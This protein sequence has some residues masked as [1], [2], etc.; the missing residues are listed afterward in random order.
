MPQAIKVIDDHA[1]L[2][3]R[4]AVDA[5]AQYEL[6]SV[7]N[8]TYLYQ[9][10]SVAGATS[11]IQ[12]FTNG[13]QTAVLKLPVLESATAFQ[14]LGADSTPYLTVDTTPTNY[15]RLTFWDYMRFDRT[16]ITF[17]TEGGQFDNYGL[18]WHHPDFG[19]TVIAQFSIQFDLGDP[20]DVKLD[21]TKMLAIHSGQYISI[22]SDGSLYLRGATGVIVD[23]GTAQQNPVNLSNLADPQADRD[24]V[25]RQYADTTYAYD[26]D[27]A[28]Y[29]NVDGSVV[30]ATSQAQ[31]FTN[32]IKA[33]SLQSLTD[34]VDGLVFKNAAG[35]SIMRFN[36]SVQN[37]GIGSSASS[38]KRLS[39]VYSVVSDSGTYNSLYS[40]LLLDGTDGAGQAVG[41]GAQGS[42]DSVSDILYG[43]GVYG[44]GNISS[45]TIQTSMYGV[46]GQALLNSA[47]NNTNIL[48]G[49]FSNIQIGFGATA[50][51]TYGLLVEMPGTALG[52]IT[53]NAGVRVKTQLN[54]NI[55]TT[56]AILTDGGAVEFHS[57]ASTVTPLTVVTDN[58]STVPALT[59]KKENDTIL[60]E[61]DE[62]GLGT[63]DSLDT[64]TLF[65]QERAEMGGAQSGTTTDRVLFV[66][67]ETGTL[68]K[69]A[70]TFYLEVNGVTSESTAVS[71]QIALA[72]GSGLTN[73]SIYG[74]KVQAYNFD[75]GSTVENL[76]GSQI[77]CLNVGGATQRIVGLEVAQVA[78]SFSGTASVY[79]V[80]GNQGT[81]YFQTN[82]DMPA[83]QLVVNNSGRTTE[84]MSLRQADTT[85]ILVIDENGNV[86][87]H[88]EPED[89]TS[90][91][92]HDIT[93][94]INLGYTIGARIVNT[95]SSTD[96][97]NPNAYGNYAFLSE[98]YLS[99]VNEY[100]GFSYAVAG[101]SK[102]SAPGGAT[103][104]GVY[105]IGSAAGP[106]AN[107]VAVLAK[108][109]KEGFGSDV[110]YVKG[111]VVD[112][113]S[114][115]SG[116]ATDVIGLH[117]KSQNNSVASGDTFNLLSES[118]TAKFTGG[119][120]GYITILVTPS[121]TNPAIR[122]LASDDSTVVLDIDEAALRPTR[123][124]PLSTS[125]FISVKAHA[126]GVLYWLQFEDE[127]DYTFAYYTN[128]RRYVHQTY[129]LATTPMRN[130][131]AT[132]TETSGIIKALQV[133]NTANPASA[134]TASYKGIYATSYSE[135]GS[136][137]IN[138]LNAIEGHA[139]HQTANTCTT[140][141]S[142]FANTQ[143]LGPVTNAYG[144]DISVSSIGSGSP[145]TNGF[146]VRSIPGA[147]AGGTFTNWYGLYASGANSASITTGY[148]FYATNG[149]SYFGDSVGTS[150]PM[151][152]QAGASQT[153]PIMQV[154]G[155]GDEPYFKVNQYGV[156]VA[157]TDV[158]LLTAMKRDSLFAAADTSATKV[159]GQVTILD[160]TAADGASL[161]G[162]GTWL[163]S[164]QSNITSA[165]I[166]GNYVNATLSGANSDFNDVYLYYAGMT[167]LPATNTAVKVVGFGNY[168]PDGV[169]ITTYRG[170]EIVES[171]V[172]G[173]APP[174]VTG[175]Y[176]NLGAALSGT[177]T[178]ARN[179]HL[180]GSQ[181]SA[182]HYGI[183]LD[184]TTTAV[185]LRSIYSVRGTVELGGDSSTEPILLLKP[186]A[187]QTYATF[188]VLNTSDDPVL[189]IGPNGEIL[190]GFLDQTL[191]DA[192]LG[193]Y[194]SNSTTATAYGSYLQHTTYS[195]G[196]SSTGVK[197]GMLATLIK[198]ST[199]ADNSGS[200]IGADIL[201]Y[202]DGAG[203]IAQVTGMYSE[204][205]NNAGTITNFYG[206][207]SYT[208]SNGG[209][210][211]KSVAGHFYNANASGT[212]TD[213]Y[214]VLITDG[215]ATGTI[216]S[217]AG[218]AVGAPV[219]ATNKTVALFGT[220]TI[221]SGNYGIYNASTND[222]YFAKPLMFGDN[223]GDPTPASNTAG[224]Y[225]K[226]VSGTVH[227]FAIDELG[228][229]TQ[230]SPHDA[231]TGEWIFYSENVRTGRRMRVNME[232]LI[233]DLEDL[234]GKQYIY[235]D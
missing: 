65:V 19:D 83:L 208:Y 150:T 165:A 215:T 70:A 10:G 214:G 18:K 222:N 187:G 166:W 203:T 182:D 113:P 30:G 72:A 111:I 86:G 4:G 219:S 28:N 87:L 91:H 7:A 211:T 164:S 61:V 17:A 44:R 223:A 42:I 29:L 98:S 133:S 16:G 136:S 3:N 190:S 95:T 235:T 132:S 82:G 21:T 48:A 199:H 174:D 231:E 35:T 51:Q 92:I 139:V 53:T 149:E 94:D 26:S 122:V 220:T 78:D 9:D 13:I 194:S 170:V 195:P 89:Y 228:N 32:G 188:E 125:D 177:Q 134:S 209:S 52:N 15:D 33:Q 40:Y 117:I 128:D 186:A 183:Y 163:T 144:V 137:S 178:I 141:T 162:Q 107:A 126:S 20:I 124:E 224:V 108:P 161:M 184:L 202:I 47:T 103:S 168:V 204:A 212:Q 189:R 14:L 50:G 106:D 123:I 181:D 118:G 155:D 105:A 233:R 217:H 130:Y 43:V 176:V 101:W 77:S 172:F 5:H 104:I 131:A 229:A 167:N 200:H 185:P 81:A 37:A 109:K 169:G 159:Y 75:S 154:I 221:P 45:S 171:I 153:V 116:T 76:V 191:P 226:D 62:V 100:T 73:R 22:I 60:F 193:I 12:S 2:I 112:T 67:T 192:H 232:E 79:S 138:L 206:F 58:A 41:I 173:S 57:G 99:G 152:I 85:P 157:G 218:I 71:T 27:L 114:I 158:N 34:G 210:A 110:G 121:S 156:P 49:L 175:V 39:T 151:T 127:D 31:Q 25:N 227:A 38:S 198:D 6:V 54:A 55:T 69:Y 96:T 88:S 66:G 213:V 135:I 179:I 196:Q 207:R 102:V 234:L 64:Q 68:Y 216:T 84:L 147:I 142:L 1:E 46:Y 148:N 230:I 146:G 201:V 180:A 93:Q 8:S 119:A 120:P 97:I 36:T 160:N 205:I 23:D 225:A 63:L 90:F 145:I 80:Y 143:A 115:S 74:E 140:L 24:A 56:Y 59:V 11:Q 129:D 197:Y